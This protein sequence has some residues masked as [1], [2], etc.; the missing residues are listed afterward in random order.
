MTG[1]NRKAL[2]EFGNTPP[3]HPVHV[4]TP[5]TPVYGRTIQY[6]IPDPQPTFIPKEITNLQAICG[7]FL[8]PAR[9]VD[10]TMLLAINELSILHYIATN[11][12]AEIL[13]RRSDMI[14][15]ANS[16]AAYL[17]APKVR[18]QAAGYRYLGN[19][20]NTVQ[21]ARPRAVSHH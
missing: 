6:D 14:L 1:Y 5:Y 11:L 16:D 15:C 18:S 8:Y 9:T 17:V 10:N 13:Y 20:S 19:H 3:K 12:D 4:P 7:K 21:R 2:K